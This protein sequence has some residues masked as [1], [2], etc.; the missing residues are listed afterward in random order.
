[1]GQIDNGDRGH[2]PANLEFLKK[3]DS[4]RH[5]KSGACGGN[6][7]RRGKSLEA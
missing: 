6:G 4:K 1:M 5:L 3:R 7:N 2:I